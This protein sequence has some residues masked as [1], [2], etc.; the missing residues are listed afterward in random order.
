MDTLLAR[1]QRGI[2]VRAELL[3]NQLIT[4]NEL[5]WFNFVKINAFGALVLNSLG[6]C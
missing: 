1:V 6:D 3:I 5:H 2:E 4:F